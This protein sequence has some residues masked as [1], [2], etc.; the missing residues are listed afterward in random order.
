LDEVTSIMPAA[1]ATTNVGAL[2]SQGYISHAANQAIN[3]TGFN[4]AGVTVGVLSDSA[5]PGCIAARIAAG[6]LPADTTVLPGQDGSGEDEG[7]AMM[8]IVHDIAPGAKLIF[9]TAF[10]GVSSF[11]ANILALQA[12]G[13]NVIVDD[14]TYFNEGA[15]Q[16]GRRGMAGDH[17]RPDALQGGALLG[18]E[19]G[20]HHRREAGLQRQGVMHQ[21]DE[22]QAVLLPPRQARQ[23]AER[24]AV[25]QDQGVVGQGGQ[26][27]G[28]G[29]AI[30]LVGERE[31]G[32]PLQHLHPPAVVA[33]GLGQPA[34]VDRAAGALVQWARQGEIEPRQG[35]PRTRRGPRGSRSG[36]RAAW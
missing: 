24:Q 16:D 4:G 14:V 7:C 35:D 19:G 23:G 12:A 11:A 6:D 21:G 15:F 10:N 31:G 33:Q 2:T 28:H 25:D 26:R 27:G 32:G 30:V 8:E 18:G 36:S 1:R 34:V 9:A 17:N 20:R 3:A 22:P 5:S 13:A 29:E